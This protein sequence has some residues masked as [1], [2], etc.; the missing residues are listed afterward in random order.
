MSGQRSGFAL[1]EVMV[2][3]LLMAAAL[4]V[5]LSA[6]PLAARASREAALHGVASHL[7]QTEM[8]RMRA[9]GYANMASQTK[10]Y[11]MT[12]TGNGTAQSVPYTST[13]TVSENPTNR[14]LLRVVVSWTA[15]PGGA[16]E[17]DTYVANI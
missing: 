3:I 16:L 11:T 4:F 5:L 9:L 12:V 1:N 2:A 10:T 15:D 7:L 14:K 6:F 17:A 13:V 8:E